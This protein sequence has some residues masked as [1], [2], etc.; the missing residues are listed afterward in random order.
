VAVGDANLDRG[1]LP[2]SAPRGI[3]DGFPVISPN[4]MEGRRALLLRSIVVSSDG[5]NRILNV[6]TTD[7]IASEDTVDQMASKT[8]EIPYENSAN[9]QLLLVHYNGWPHRW[10]E[11]IRS[12]SPRLRAFRT[13]TRHSSSLS[14]ASP[15]IHSAYVDSPATNIVSK[16]DE[17]LERSAVLSEV[18]RVMND[19]QGFLNAVTSDLPPLTQEQDEQHFRDAHEDEEEDEMKEEVL[20]QEHLMQV[21]DEDGEYYIA[22]HSAFQRPHLPWQTFSPDSSTACAPAMPA[23][24]AVKSHSHDCDG[25]EETIPSSSRGRTATTR[26]DLQALA[27]LFDRLGRTLTHLAPHVAAL[28]ATFPDSS[29]SR[30]S[31][32]ATS[33][34][35]E[36]EE[37]VIEENDRAYSEEVANKTDTEQ[38]ITDNSDVAGGNEDNQAELLLIDAPVTTPTAFF[39]SATRSSTTGEAQLQSRQPD[40]YVDFVNGMVHTRLAGSSSSSFMSGINSARGG[41]RNGRDRAA[42]IASFLT[43]STGSESFSSGVAVGGSN[44]GVD[45]NAA[46]EGVEVDEDGTTSDANATAGLPSDGASFPENLARLFAGG[47]VSDGGGIDIH[48][49]AFVTPGFLPGGLLFGGLPGVLGTSTVDTTPSVSAVSASAS[50][51]SSRVPLRHVENEEDLGLFD[52]L[53]GEPTPEVSEEDDVCVT[54]PFLQQVVST[55]DQ[56]SL[57]SN[58]ADNAVHGENAESSED[59]S[60]NDA[61][62]VP[63]PLSE[64]NFENLTGSDDNAS[65]QLGVTATQLEENIHDSNISNQDEL[66]DSSTASGTDSGAEQ[67]QRTMDDGNGS[68]D[69]TSLE[70]RSRVEGEQDT[71]SLDTNDSTTARRDLLSVLRRY[72]LGRGSR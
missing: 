54:T 66:S 52:E 4:D 11:W 29:T 27:A 45:R 30:T 19:V 31:D 22:T 60:R 48:I 44:V 53:Y 56:R 26:T 18:S 9:V 38:N 1:P 14:F 6:S 21:D 49:H 41:A 63:V 58:N 55:D 20:E 13:R 17:Q 72:T 10:D 69:A 12:D 61:I 70:A 62:H 46:A 64:D 57:E 35:S 32:T 8:I 67:G 5:S 43:N 40:E 51:T 37:I 42:A 47:G 7:S 16:E 71:S 28:A 34:E 23:A 33:R 15:S 25:S 50:E 2:S 59:I 65:E 24:R 3:F 36:Q 39:P 68:A